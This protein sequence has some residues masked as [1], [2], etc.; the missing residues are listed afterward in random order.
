MQLVSCQNSFEI[1]GDHRNNILTV[2]T[3]NDDVSNACCYYGIAGLVSP[4]SSK[5]GLTN[6]KTKVHWIIS[7]IDTR[8]CARVRA[9]VRGGW[10]GLGRWGPRAYATNKRVDGQAVHA[11][12]MLLWCAVAEVDG[13]G[14][15]HACVGSMSSSCG[16]WCY[17]VRPDEMM[18]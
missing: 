1:N 16:L 18:W 6:L 8:S 3:A 10:G 5:L 2:A 12:V 13:G 11:R 4:R 17:V 14:G 7:Y 15:V 9:C